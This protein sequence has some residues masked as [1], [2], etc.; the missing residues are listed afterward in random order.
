MKFLTKKLCEQGVVFTANEQWIPCFAHTLNLG[1]QAALSELR[2]APT[3]ND[4]VDQ[5]SYVEDEPVTKLRV[6][7]IKV[8][9]IPIQRRS[10]ANAVHTFHRT[11]PQLATDDGAVPQVMQNAQDQRVQVDTRRED[12]LELNVRDDPPCSQV[13]RGP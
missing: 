11:D 2:I 6:L 7:I 1:V 8:S 10:I 4:D 5:E 12:T 3:G 13:P 9:G